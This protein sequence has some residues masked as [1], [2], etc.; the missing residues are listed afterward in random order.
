M[1]N[2]AGDQS[3]LKRINRMALVRFIKAEPG[4]CRVELA[5]R[6]GLTK[7]TVG[8]LVAELIEE[9]WL[10]EG[11]PT[12]GNGVGRRP[13]PLAIDPN[14]IALMGAEI[15]VD[16]INVIACNLHGEILHSQ[17]IPYHHDNVDKSIA[18]LSAIISNIRNT[19][20]EQSRRPLGI[21]IGVPGMVD[22]NNG[23]LRFAPN[24]GWH[25]LPLGKYI[26]ASLAKFGANDLEVSLIN[27]AN[28]AALSEYVFGM[29]RPNGPLVYISMGIG[30][31][32]G[33]VLSD[34]LYVGH[35]GLA[36][37]VGH[38]FLQH[39]GPQCACGRHG[40]AETFISQQAI[41]RDILGND[42]EVIPIEELA[43]RVQDNDP[44]VIE[45]TKRAGEYLGLLIQ[46]LGYTINPSLIV[47]GGP[48]CQLGD[49]LIDTAITN[50]Q[51]SSGKY[52][53]QK[54]SIQQCRFGIN[55]CA[56]GAAG[57]VFQQFL[58]P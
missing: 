44:A 13:V 45:A 26:S 19:L 10:C 1:I 5:Q 24:I 55:A 53:Q 30:L 15:G 41:S 18:E 42:N 46:N 28:A 29:P 58:A 49:V 38:T 23:I 27:E 11:E 7:T 8:M 47:L 36:G 34:R 50:Y 14:R 32:A 37:E 4:L 17:C 57:A 52:D 25:D 54:V 43:I 3:L 40:C 12:S 9:G 20:I 56:V 6:T 35:D 48:L 39:S 51:H 22:S 16:Y 33:I 2:V 21:G 31:G